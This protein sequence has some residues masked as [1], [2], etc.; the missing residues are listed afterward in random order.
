MPRTLEEV[1]R[2]RKEREVMLA[3]LQTSAKA[4]EAVMQNHNQLA[5]TLKTAQGALKSV[6][7]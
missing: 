3:K 4:A 2:K 6:N 5:N 1:A 7:D